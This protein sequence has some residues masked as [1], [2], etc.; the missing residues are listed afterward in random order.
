MNIILIKPYTHPLS[1]KV[2]EEGTPMLVTKDYGQ[3]LIDLGYAQEHKVVSIAE[4]L[5]QICFAATIKN[6]EEEE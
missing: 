1:G 5:D 3:S 6:K 4:I 2:I